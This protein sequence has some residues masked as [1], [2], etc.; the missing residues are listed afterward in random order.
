MLLAVAAKAA[1]HPSWWDEWGKVLPGWLAFTWV[2]VNAA[3][4]GFWVRGHHI[5]LGPDNDKLR[6]ALTTTRSLFE[7]ITSAGGRTAKWF[8]D[9]ERRETGRALRDHAERRSDKV[10]KDALVAV[11]ASWDE[12]FSWSVPDRPMVHWEGRQ[13]TPQEERELESDN[14]RARKQVEEAHRG[15][16]HIERAVNRLNELERKT[17]GRS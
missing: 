17:V 12:V 15:L 7:D 16:Q 6:A 3:W 11:A 9:E 14:E 2:I 5:A 10:L 4:K 1:E 8:L 13:R